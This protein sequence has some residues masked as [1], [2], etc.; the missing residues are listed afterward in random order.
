MNPNFAE[1][2]L[3]G[4]QFLQFTE[5]NTLFARDLGTLWGPTPIEFDRTILDRFKDGTRPY[6]TL[7]ERIGAYLSFEDAVAGLTTIGV[8]TWFDAPQ[9]PNAL[10]LGQV[11]LTRQVT[12]AGPSF[13]PDL[14]IPNCYISEPD[15]F[16]TP[17]GLLQQGYGH[18]TGMQLFDDGYCI[19]LGQARLGTAEFRPDI[20]LTHYVNNKA[21]ILQVRAGAF[22]G[23]G[24]MAKAVYG[25]NF[26]RILIQGPQG[27]KQRESDA[28]EQ[29][30]LAR[31]QKTLLPD[32]R[33]V[34]VY[35]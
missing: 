13:A 34:F 4:D 14:T 32:Q 18:V 25:I 20:A 10:Q 29:K 16:L 12:L 21:L 28:I 6:Y 7:A 1:G 3:Q 27:P 15:T 5:L 26:L 2:D 19:A 33:T 23:N 30:R 35:Y 31:Q 11:T 24:Q 8:E 22:S 17:E 9:T